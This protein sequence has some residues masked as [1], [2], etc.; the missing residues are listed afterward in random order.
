MNTLRSL[1]A[2]YPGK[3]QAKAHLTHFSN[4][5]KA[6]LGMV[7]MTTYHYWLIYSKRPTIVVE[8][9]RDIKGDDEN[10]YH[11]DHIIL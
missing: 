7:R 5:G 3:R 4:F 6:W 2:A 9:G 11:D 10:D 1:A 8:L